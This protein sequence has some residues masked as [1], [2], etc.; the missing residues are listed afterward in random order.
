MPQLLHLGS[1]SFGV[2]GDEQVETAA[3]ILMSGGNYMNLFCL[4][5]CWYTVL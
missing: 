4:C 3:E 2:T 1:K 5:Y